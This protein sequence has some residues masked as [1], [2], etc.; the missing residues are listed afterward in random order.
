LIDDRDG[1]EHLKA[2]GGVPD[3]IPPEKGLSVSL[4]HQ[5]THSVPTTPIEHREMDDVDYLAL[6]TLLF[7][8][9]RRGKAVERGFCPSCRSQVTVK[10]EATCPH[11]GT[12][13]RGSD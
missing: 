11:C 6:A 7:L 4:R 8:I 1:G 12:T 2:W 5:L 3:Q 10:L 13:H 9:P